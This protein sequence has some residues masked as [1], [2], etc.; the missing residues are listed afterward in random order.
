M[1][2]YKPFGIYSGEIVDP[3]QLT[4]EFTEAKKIA[5]NTTSW[6]WMSSKDSGLNYDTMAENGAGVI[7]EQRQRAAY[8]DAGKG[9]NYDANNINNN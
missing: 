1:S 7:V 4:K 8:I 5:E 6:Q 9:K 2:L 3:D